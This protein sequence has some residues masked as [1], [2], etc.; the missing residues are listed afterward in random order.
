MSK[1]LPIYLFSKT[2][3]PDVN[4]VPI[5][6]TE[7]FQPDIDFSSYDAI[8]LTSKQAVAALEKID[9]SWTELPVLTI[10]DPTAELAEKAGASVMSRGD[11]YGNSLA[12]IIT[13]GYPKKRWLY[14]RPEVVAS[15]FAQKVRHAGVDLEDIVVYKTSCNTEAGSKKIEDRAI[16]IFTSPFTIACFLNFYTFKPTHTVIAIG[17]TTRSA[18]PENIHAYIPEKP[19]VDSCVKLAGRLMM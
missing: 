8:V 2:S 14:P 4:Y 3:H 19:S 16:L 9:N 15:D 10:A 7:F 11:G 5:L 13:T 1:H 17:K 18:L 12:D 6:S